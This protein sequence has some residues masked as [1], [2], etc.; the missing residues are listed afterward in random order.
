MVAGYLSYLNRTLGVRFQNEATASFSHALETVR[1]GEADLIAVA[2]GE[3]A[4]QTGLLATQPY[5]T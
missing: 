1:E 5:A 4:M 3:N 2:V